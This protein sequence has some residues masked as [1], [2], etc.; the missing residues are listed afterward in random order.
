MY[1]VSQREKRK[2]AAGASLNCLVKAP[3]GPCTLKEMF[4]LPITVKWKDLTYDVNVGAGRGP[5]GETKML[6]IL[7]SVEG[8]AQAGECLAIMGPS[9][10]GKTTL[11]DILS[12]RKTTGYIGSALFPSHL[13]LRFAAPPPPPHPLRSL[14]R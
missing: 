13:P 8:A 6:R 11:A 2:S 1:G 5:S 12:F 9:G 3:Q 10:A 4:T 7:H 14:L